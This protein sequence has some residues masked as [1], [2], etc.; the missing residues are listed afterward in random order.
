MFFFFFFYTLRQ[1]NS[2]D[3]KLPA[4]TICQ[5]IDSIKKTRYHCSDRLVFDENQTK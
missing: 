4:T 5:N 3:N 1:Y 2:N